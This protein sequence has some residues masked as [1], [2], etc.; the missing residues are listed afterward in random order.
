MTEWVAGRFRI[1]NLVETDASSAVQEIFSQATP[2]T[3]TGIRWL[4]PHFAHARGNLN[5]VVQSFLVSDDV[6]RIVIDTCVGNVK[7][8]APFKDFNGLQTDFLGRFVS[9]GWEPRM[10]TH[11]VTLL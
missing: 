11:V 8:R 3:I 10:V 1:R 6:H 2:D 7:Q 9:L 4:A 5:G